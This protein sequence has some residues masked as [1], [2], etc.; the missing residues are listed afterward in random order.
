MVEMSVLLGIKSRGKQENG[1]KKRAR[2]LRV[3]QTLALGINLARGWSLDQIPQ[4][5]KGFRGPVNRHFGLAF[6]LQARA[7]QGLA[8]PKLAPLFELRRQAS[9]RLEAQP[10]FEPG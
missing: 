5:R 7:W 9:E 1:H 10:G 3:P 4:P 2:L 8:E 6:A